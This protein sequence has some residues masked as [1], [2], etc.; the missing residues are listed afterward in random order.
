MS[1]LLSSYMTLGQ[2]PWSTSKNQGRQGYYS[3]TM[4]AWSWKEYQ[5]NHSS[6]LMLE[7]FYNI[8]ISCN[9]AWRS[10]VDSVKHLLN[11]K[12]CKEER[13]FICVKEQH[14]YSTNYST[15][16]KMIWNVFSLCSE[17]QEN[18][19]TWQRTQKCETE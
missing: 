1:V 12:R 4:D 8:Y 13:I 6:T 17:A 16:L 15:L 19:I 10:L 3:T 14:M 2:G 18:Q 11:W 9:A 5:N 7:F